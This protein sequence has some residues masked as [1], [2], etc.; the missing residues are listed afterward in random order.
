MLISSVPVPLIV[1][2]I[3]GDGT[4]ELVSPAVLEA[5]MKGRAWLREFLVA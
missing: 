5:A 2:E 4:V 1:R 3:S